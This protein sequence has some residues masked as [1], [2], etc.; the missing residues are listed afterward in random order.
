MAHE[1]DDR[2]LDELKFLGKKLSEMTELPVILSSMAC[3][4]VLLTHSGKSGLK[5]GQVVKE[6]AV[7]FG[8]K[9]GGSDTLAQ[10]LFSDV[11]IMRN[12]VNIAIHSV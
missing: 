2:N 4:T 5:C 9:G 1:F 6:F 8:G 7:G 3:N 12:F 11:E 10:A